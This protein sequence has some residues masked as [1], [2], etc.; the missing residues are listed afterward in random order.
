[1]TRLLLSLIMVLAASVSPA[2]AHTGIGG[3]A[4]FAHGFGHPFSGL[5][6]IL[7][8]VAAGLYAA[9]LGG[10][11]IYLVPLAF[12][13]MMAVGGALGIV[14]IGVPYVETGIALSVIV[15]GAALAVPFR[16]STAAAMC[17]VGFFALFHG[18]AHGAEM[19]V[20]AA[21]LEYGLGFVLA[22]G[23]L[24]VIGIGIG[25]GTGLVAE[26]YSGRIAQVSGAG[27]AIA[28]TVLLAGML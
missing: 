14:G 26:R 5:D 24:H 19:P 10:R 4:G 17:L 3:T 20:D 8:M 15:F 12:M 13:A 16:L 2:E 7:A 9:H 28:G 22:T 11:S 18:H 27:M 6:H 21:G 1:M 23:V 25:L